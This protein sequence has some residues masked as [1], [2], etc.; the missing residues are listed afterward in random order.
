MSSFKSDVGTTDKIGNVIAA[1]NFSNY[2]APS[3][4][5]WLGRTLSEAF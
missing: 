3:I 5:D 2:S 1:E 4:L